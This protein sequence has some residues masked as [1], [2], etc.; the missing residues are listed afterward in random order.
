MSINEFDPQTINTPGPRMDLEIKLFE[1]RDWVS[2]TAYTEL[3]AQLPGLSD[4]IRQLRKNHALT[5]GEVDYHKRINN[6]H[7]EMKA[8]I[9][10]IAEFI[11]AHYRD[12]ISLG[13]HGAFKT[14]ADCVKFYM[15]RERILSKKAAG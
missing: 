2:L 3:K 5:D 12:E 7:L 4:E 14:L 15:G 6:E 13:Q 1:G 10:E 11:R 8:T 9:D